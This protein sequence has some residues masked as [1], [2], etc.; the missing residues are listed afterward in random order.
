MR[1][2]WVQKSAVGPKWSN[3]QTFGFKFGLCSLLLGISSWK[4]EKFHMGQIWGTFGV[5]T[6]FW[7]TKITRSS[8]KVRSVL[9]RALSTISLQIWT[10][11]MILRNLQLQKSKDQLDQL[12]PTCAPFRVMTLFEFI[13][14]QIN[15]FYL[16][17]F[18][19]K[20]F[21]YPNFFS[22]IFFTQIFF[23]F[24]FFFGTFFLDNIFFYFFY[25]LPHLTTFHR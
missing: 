20:F 15:F 3:Y 13:F 12:R 2:F 24:F 11:H 22:Q 21:F 7:G 16:I 10:V 23:F 1:K 8:Q 17:F 14:S 6:P 4:T 5:L 18:L 9:N 25:F 19:P